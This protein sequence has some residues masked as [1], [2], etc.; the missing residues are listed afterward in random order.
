MRFFSLS[1]LLI[2]VATIGL[3]TGCGPSKKPEVRVNRY[4][5]PM[6]GKTVQYA[7]RGKATFYADKYQGQATAS[8]EPYDKSKMTCAHPSLPFGTRLRVTNIETG[9]SVIVKV[10]DRFPGQKG[11]VVDL[12]KSAFEQLAPLARGVIDVEIE[13]V[14]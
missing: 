5:A 9:K 7:Q 2:L 12:S 11:R 6:T 14:E 3:A 8:G 1:L 4:E 13:A 10:N